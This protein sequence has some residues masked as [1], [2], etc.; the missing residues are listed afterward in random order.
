MVQVLVY[1]IFAHRYINI[2]SLRC[3]VCLFARTVNRH[4][5]VT[6]PHC[7]CAHRQNK[8][9]TQKNHTELNWTEKQF[10]NFKSNGLII[11]ICVCTPRNSAPE[12]VHA[13]KGCMSVVVTA[14]FTLDF[15]VRTFVVSSLKNSV[16]LRK[17]QE[18]D[19]G[20]RF[21][22]I[23]NQFNWSL[24]I[25]FVRSQEHGWML[26]FL[27]ITLFTQYVVR[28]DATMANR[29]RWRESNSIFI[30]TN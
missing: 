30:G 9:R 13:V 20:P 3:D 19:D 25:P 21:G 14:I 11:V 1:W 23:F 24:L 26:I 29:D 6:I 18:R 7:S 27:F 15:N 16:V 4:K 28:K 2:I 12:T 8:K 5:R 22:I 10:R 17:N